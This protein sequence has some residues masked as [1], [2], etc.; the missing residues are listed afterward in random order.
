MRIDLRGWLARLDRPAVIFHHRSA[1][2]FSLES[3]PLY[4]S[5]VSRPHPSVWGL[6]TRLWPI[7]QIRRNVVWERH[8]AQYARAVA[9]VFP[10]IS[11]TT[12]AESELFSFNTGGKKPSLIQ[13]DTGNRLSS[14]SL[15]P[16]SH[17][18]NSDSEDGYSSDE[19]GTQR[20]RK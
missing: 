14:S 1:K 5:L 2:V 19:D 13:L 9:R 4:D 10:F 15:A 8:L 11:Y 12:M 17:T 18:V 3:F 16:T 20:R 7:S 6:G